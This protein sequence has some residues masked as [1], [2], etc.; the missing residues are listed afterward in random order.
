MVLSTADPEA[1]PHFS[2]KRKRFLKRAWEYSFQ[3][4]VTFD[5]SY[6]EN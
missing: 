1:Q 5:I 4:W 6:N 2:K 3:I